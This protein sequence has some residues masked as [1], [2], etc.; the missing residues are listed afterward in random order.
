VEPDAP[1]TDICPPGQWAPDTDN[2]RDWSHDCSPHSGTHFTVYSDGSSLEAKTTLAGL[3]E[4]TF[5][6]LTG[7]FEI[8]SDDELRIETGYTFWIYAIR[9]IT[10]A[11]AEGYRNGLVIASVDQGPS[12]GV[13]YR[14][15]S[16]YHYT[17]RHELTHV[18]QFALTDCPKN[19]A[20]PD[21][22]DFWFREGQAV[23]L[24]GGYTKPTVQEF[25]EWLA[26]PT[27]V[28]P[29]QIKRWPDFP[30]PDRLGEYYQIFGLAYAWLVDTSDGLG[31]SMADMRDLFEQ[32]AGG[33]PFN[34][35]FEAA[36]GMGL[37]SLEDQFVDF[38]LDYLPVAVP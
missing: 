4:D 12:P 32:M 37:A 33:E 24:G 30:D 14:H 17:L 2:Y 23:V 9:Y 28:N 6:D 19:S 31:A 20:C 38:M 13:Y 7:E 25:E 36:V 26:D 27:H 15:P 8:E 29:I 35:A 22:L 21:W 3:A 16:W 18:F 34:D 11:V 5:A 1:A 10:P